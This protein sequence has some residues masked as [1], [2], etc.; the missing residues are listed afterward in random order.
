MRAFRHLAQL[1]LFEDF[2]PEQ[3]LAKLH[4]LL[5]L[6]DTQVDVLLSQPGLDVRIPSRDECRVVGVALEVFFVS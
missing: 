2:P 6:P 4:V 1:P 5:D 3:L